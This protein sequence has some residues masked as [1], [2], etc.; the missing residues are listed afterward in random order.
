M[1]H[2]QEYR[3]R[4]IHSVIPWGDLPMEPSLFEKCE[5]KFHGLER[6]LKQHLAMNLDENI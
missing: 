4:Q 3:I 6:E 5:L 1:V 2:I